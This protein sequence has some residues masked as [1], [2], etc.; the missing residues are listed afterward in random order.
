MIAQMVF[1]ISRPVDPGLVEPSN[2]ALV[3]ETDPVGI[4]AE[5]AKDV[6]GSAE[7]AFGVDE[8]VG[9]AHWCDSGL[10]ASG[11]QAEM[12][13]KTRQLVDTEQPATQRDKLLTLPVRGPHGHHRDVRGRHAPRCH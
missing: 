3:G 9:L 13:A 11:T 2:E 8:P 4:A 12:I 1:E 7:W 6:V 5:V 10:L